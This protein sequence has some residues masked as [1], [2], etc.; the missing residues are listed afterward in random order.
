MGSYLLKAQLQM[1]LLLLSI[2]LPL[3]KKRFYIA[4]DKKKLNEVNQNWKNH[5]SI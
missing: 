4:L 3:T 5:R 2:Y 1:Q